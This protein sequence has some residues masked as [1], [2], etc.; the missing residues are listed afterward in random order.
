[1]VEIPWELALPHKLL[2]F[3]GETGGCIRHS[4]F[5]KIPHLWESFP[6][7][8]FCDAGNERMTWIL[9]RLSENFGPLSEDILRLKDEN[10]G[11]L[12]EY[13]LKERGDSQDE[14][15]RTASTANFHTECLSF[16]QTLVCHDLNETLCYYL[17]TLD[18]IETPDLTSCLQS[19]AFFEPSSGVATD[20][21]SYLVNHGASSTCQHT[22]ILRVNLSHVDSCRS[23]TYVSARLLT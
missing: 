16:L 20:G 17:I 10:L 3:Y 19:A 11:N 7:H 22:V 21:S 2:L 1:M 13:L 4:K 23:H 14:C 8:V 12:F 15:S 18:E 5:V 9:H 6:G